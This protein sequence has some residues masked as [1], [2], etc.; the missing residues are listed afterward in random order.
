MSFDSMD[1]RQM[2]IAVLGNFYWQQASDQNAIA[3]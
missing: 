3:A 1:Q 2:F